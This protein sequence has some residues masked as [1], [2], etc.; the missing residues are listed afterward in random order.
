MITLTVTECVCLAAM[1]AILMAG[2]FGNSLVIFVFGCKKRKRTSYETLLLTLGI[3]DLFG[4]LLTP[5]LFIYWTLTDYKQWHFGEI[6]CKIIPSV[7]P[8]NVSISQ[9]ILILISFERYYG[10]VN[11]FKRQML[12]RKRLCIYVLIIVIVA[13]TLASPYIYTLRITEDPKFGTKT[14]IPRQG[15]DILL[16]S[17]NFGNSVIAVVRDITALSVLTLTNLR[18]AKAIHSSFGLATQSVRSRRLSSYKKL[19]KMLSAMVA[20]LS[21]CVIPVD[22]LKCGYNICYVIDRTAITPSAYEI[23]R[24]CNT[25]LFVLQVANCFMNV[26]IYAGM[27]PEFKSSIKCTVCP[28]NDQ[29]HRMKSRKTEESIQLKPTMVT[30]NICAPYENADCIPLRSFVELE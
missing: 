20:S 19:R 15:D 30:E 28:C 26:I 3:V 16:I 12:T 21:I 17:I 27:D 9:G 6:G 8:V 13:F 18:M 24:Q 23:F 2:T 4:S 25:F 29:R 14:C 11:P 5:A 22:L 10:T 1:F 7:L